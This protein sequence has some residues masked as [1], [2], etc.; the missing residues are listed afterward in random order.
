LGRHA[1]DQVE[2]CEE[3]LVPETNR[4]RGMGEEGDARLDDVAMFPL[5][6]AVLLRRVWASNT[7][8][9]TGVIKIFGETSVLAAT[10]R[11]HHA[12]FSLK[13]SFHVGLKVIKRFLNIGL[14][15]DKINPCITTKIIH[16][17][18]IVPKTSHRRDSWPPYIGMH[19]L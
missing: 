16:K 5:G 6:D 9:N 14:A 19:E 8:V 10:I 17:T 7:M 4:K 12:N 1:V 15:L 3:S 2:G 13:Q 11:L 18:Y